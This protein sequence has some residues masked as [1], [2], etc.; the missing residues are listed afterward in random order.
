[1][2]GIPASCARIPVARAGKPGSS[3]WNPTERKNH[4]RGNEHPHRARGAA[5][6]PAQA[7]RFP[8]GNAS[9]RRARRGRTPARGPVPVARSLYA[10]PHECGQVLCQAGRCRCGDGGRDGR[11]RRTLAAS[12]FHRGRDRAVPLRLAAFC[13]LGRNRPAQARSGRGAGDDRARRVGHAG[14]HRL[15]RTADD[16]ASETGRNGRGRGRQRRGGIGGR[17]GRAHQGRA[18]GRYRRRRGKMPFRQGTAWFRRGR[19]SGAPPIS[20]NS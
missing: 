15:C 9:C 7:E 8:G 17:P 19:R 14:L 6:R 10:R 1:M 12:R 4:V 5:D 18:G 16:R 13:P 20:R 11:S 2:L 3:S